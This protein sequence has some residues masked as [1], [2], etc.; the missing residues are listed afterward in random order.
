MNKDN[1][2]RVN[3][4][5]IYRKKNPIKLKNVPALMEK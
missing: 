3:I 5:A 1:F 4:E 2:W